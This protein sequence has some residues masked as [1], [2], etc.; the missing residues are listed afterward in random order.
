MRECVNTPEKES[1]LQGFFRLVAW[2]W[3]NKH[4]HLPGGVCAF[5]CV[6]RFAGCRSNILSDNEKKKKKKM[7]HISK[8]HHHQASNDRIAA[9]I[10]PPLV[11]GERNEIP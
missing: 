10:I 8:P 6:L 7:Y 4:K 9:S 1:I 3:R 5:V 11:D 2:K